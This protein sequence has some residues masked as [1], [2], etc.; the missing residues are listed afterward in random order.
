MTNPA[1]HCSLFAPVGCGTRCS[2]DE[3]P[4]ALWKTIPRMSIRETSRFGGA[5]QMKDID[6]EDCMK[7]SK[8]LLLYAC[9]PLLFVA[10]PIGLPAATDTPADTQA[11]KN[12]IAAYAASV[13]RADTKSAD[14]VFSNAPE[15]TFIHPLG[16]EHGRDQIEANV[17]RNL[18]GAT[19]SERKLTPKD[20]AVHVYGDT[21]W[22]EFNWDFVAKVRK[23]GS[24]ALLLARV[25]ACTG[26]R[27]AAGAALE[28]LL[29]PRKK[30]CVVRRF[31]D[32]R[33][34]LRSARGALSPRWR[35]TARSGC[36]KGGL[37]ER[38]GGQRT[39]VKGWPC[40]RSRFVPPGADPSARRLAR[41]A[42][43]H[44]RL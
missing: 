2:G 29:R 25:P 23:D 5:R 20:L 26:T 16:E 31:P 14:Q 40:F 4:S 17:F 11:I 44:R 9:C 1:K 12:L 27:P 34:I 38:P 15:V 30:S 10:L 3:K 7:K 35:G 42:L 24:A 22:S 18:M 43:A 6:E 28:M 41:S 32:R 39:G 19:F 37:P 33:F 13:D 8:T 21:A 36:D